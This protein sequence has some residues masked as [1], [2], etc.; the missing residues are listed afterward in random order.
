MNKI[1]SLLTILALLIAA[2]P[3]ATAGSAS[4]PTAA[5]ISTEPVD[6]VWPPIW[7]P[8]S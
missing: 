1:R 8:G 6:Q 5:P 3:H 2:Q 4:T 7:W